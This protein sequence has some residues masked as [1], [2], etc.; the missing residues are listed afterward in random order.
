MCL[1]CEPNAQKLKE[2]KDEKHQIKLTPF[3][4]Y[5]ISFEKE[6]HTPKITIGVKINREKED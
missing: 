3:K 4:L 5:L 1:A 2:R 6:N